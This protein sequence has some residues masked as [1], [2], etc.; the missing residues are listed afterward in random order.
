MTDTLPLKSIYDIDLSELR[1]IIE[2]WDAPTYRVNQIWRGLYQNLWHSPEE[3]T[4]L[5]KYLRQYLENQ[6]LFSGLIPQTTVETTDGSTKKTLF[7][8]KDGQAIESVLMLYNRNG[9]KRP[10]QTLCISTQ[11]G[12]ALG[13]VFC[14][15]GQMGFKRNLTSGEIIEQVIYYE[16]G[17]RKFGKRV[18]NVVLMGMGEPFNNYEATMRAIKRLNH[19]DGLNLGSRRFTIST[20]GIVPAIKRF[21][22]VNSQVNLAI[23]LHAADDELRNSLLPINRKY[24]LEVLLDACQDYVNQTRRRI[25][26]EWALIDGVNDSLEQSEKL[27]QH[28]KRFN[29]S[30]SMLCHV[31]I[32]PLNPTDKFPR[33]ATQRQKVLEFQSVLK[34]SG[35][36]CSIRL[37]RGIDIQAGCGQ[38]AINTIM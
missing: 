20:V 6:Y 3:F 23:S 2:S 7:R 8:L 11:V 10:R 22:S 12:C 21:T 17:L 35:I 26:F 1:E 19:P 16:R 24:P 37:R 34:R 31:N 5:P 33:K 30:G 14:A 13:C 15:T 36:P 27:S 9:N 4:T 25:T 38:L 18:T 32:I 29:F 28:L